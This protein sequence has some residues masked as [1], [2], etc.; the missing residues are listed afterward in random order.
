MKIVFG[1]KKNYPRIWFMYSKVATNKQV[2]DF[3]RSGSIVFISPYNSNLTYIVSR[4]EKTRMP[5][6]N[7]KFFIKKNIKMINGF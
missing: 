2:S 1:T 6:Q 7:F 3:L 4:V 5:T